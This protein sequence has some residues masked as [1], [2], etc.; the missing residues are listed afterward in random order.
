MQNIK[1]SITFMVCLG[2]FLVPF[3]KWLLVGF[4]FHHT[5]FKGWALF[6]CD[7]CLANSSRIWIFLSLL[8]IIQ[9]G[10]QNAHIKVKF[11][12]TVAW[13]CLWWF[14]PTNHKTELTHTTDFYDERAH[15]E[16]KSLALTGHIKWCGRLT[17]PGGLAFDTCVIVDQFCEN[18]HTDSV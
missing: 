4:H 18:N 11:K 9:S 15:F 3:S 10:K 17:C 7:C 5:W 12:A 1:A 16:K 13:V 2:F 14:H 8:D 6:E